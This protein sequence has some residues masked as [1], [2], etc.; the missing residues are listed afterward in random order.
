MNRKVLVSLVVALVLGIS[1]LSYFEKPKEPIIEVV[2]MMQ[3]LPG[4]QPSYPG[5]T[6]FADRVVK[7][8]NW[9]LVL[10]KTEFGG[11]NVVAL[12]SLRRWATDNF[13][14]DPH[15]LHPIIIPVPEPHFSVFDSAIYNLVAP[16][17]Y[18]IDER[19]ADVLRWRIEEFHKTNAYKSFQVAYY[20]LFD[21]DAESA[22]LLAR[23]QSDRAKLAINVILCAVYWVIAI[24][25]GAVWYLRARQG[26]RS[27]RE[28]R[29]L[30]YGWI[31]MG[32]YYFIIAW[33][34]QQVT[35]FVSAVLALAAGFYLRRPITVSFGQDSGLSFRLISLGPRILAL[36]T[37]ISISLIAIQ[38]MTWIKSGVLSDPD[39]IT[40]LVSSFTGNFLH[41]PTST[42]R[43]ILR[44][45]GIVWVVASLWTLRFIRYEASGEREI[46][47]QL[48]SL[49]TIEPRP[50]VHTR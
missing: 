6:V 33:T 5:D 15:F 4:V 31:C 11:A 50:L 21:V 47:E 14:R 30:A 27:T 49:D 18:F 22:T 37:W 26:Q 17:K 38:G 2:N 24:V 28:Q 1:V 39:P 48:D 34:T 32:T 40:L 12:D 35:V 19:T 46:E 20:D 41:D 10:V 23:Y 43:T 3:E 16:I 25:G 36:V 45:I 44:V 13:R 7:S 8:Y 42:K 29:L 9:A